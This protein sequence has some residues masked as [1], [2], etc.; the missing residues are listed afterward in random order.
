[1]RSTFH[2]MET[3]K[4]ALFAQRNA[5]DTTGHNIANAERDGYTRQKAHMSAT[6]PY[7]MPAQNMPGTAGQIGTGVEVESVERMRDDFID[8]Q[9]RE[10]SRFKGNWENKND[11][12]KKIETLYT[13]P[14]DSGLRSVFDQFWESLQD[15]SKNPE[16]RTARTQVMERGVSLADTVN[17]MYGQFVNLKEDLDESIDIKVDE[18]NSIGHQIA[19]LN[20]QIQN[21]ELRTN[22]NANDLRDKRDMLLDELSEL[23]NYNLSED[24]KGNVRVSIGGTS[25]VE[26][27]RVNEL[28]FE[29]EAADADNDNGN[30]EGNG[31]IYLDDQEPRGGKVKWSHTGEEVNFRDGAM[32]G[33]MDSRDKIVQDH[34]DELR[35]VMAQF[36]ESFN[37]VHSDDRAFN[38]YQAQAAQDG[39]DPF[40]DDVN[41]VDNFFEWKNDGNELLTVNEEIQ[42]DVYLINAGYIDNDTLS[43]YLDGDYDDDDL[44]DMGLEDIFGD[45]YET[46][47]PE[48]MDINPNKLMYRGNGENG[49]RLANLKDEDIIKEVPS[50]DNFDNDEKISGDTTFNDYIDAVVSDLGVE[51][52]EAERMVENQE[53]LVDQL[54]NRREAVSG[55]SMDEE[56]TKMVQQQHAYNAAS[57]VVTTIDESLDTIINQMG[58]VGR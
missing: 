18:I 11:T 40:S 20:E 35:S 24:D 37:V 21:I 6:S 25:L 36:Q 47:E 17:H 15:L 13:E 44:S 33:L 10:E 48:N 22:Q 57:R 52:Q 1:M 30:N 3:A 29:A 55:V 32:G 14:S 45:N 16:D 39:E 26:G 8:S 19:D 31:N 7:T 51:A 4:R 49:K 12:L 41:Q 27:N 9:I 5:L 50:E 38:H 46:Q 43:E 53:L 42:E 58:I 34:I 54:E 28:E 2:G 56:M 23:T